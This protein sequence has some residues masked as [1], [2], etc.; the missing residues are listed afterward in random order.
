MDVKKYWSWW[1]CFSSKRKPATLRTVE[2]FSQML[3]FALLRLVSKREG[4]IQ[5]LMNGNSLILFRIQHKVVLLVLRTVFAV[6]FSLLSF[7]Q[8]SLRPTLGP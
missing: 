3:Y 4:Q 8:K 6:G 7:L 2:S 5:S 1:L